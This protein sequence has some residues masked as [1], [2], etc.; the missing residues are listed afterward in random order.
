MEW[1]I[2]IFMRKHK[3]LIILLL[4]AFTFFI[5][6]L[7]SL[8]C[9][10]M[11]VCV[12]VCCYSS[13]SMCLLSLSLFSPWH[14]YNIEYVVW[15]VVVLCSSYVYLPLWQRP[16]NTAQCASNTLGTHVLSIIPHH[17]ISLFDLLRVRISHS[18]VSIHTTLQGVRRNSQ[19]SSKLNEN[20]K[21]IIYKKWRR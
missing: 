8:R 1:R 3:F 12:C 2:E 14:P 7:L 17:R 4:S 11:R 6:T 20:K 18:F 9:M 13:G 19:R 16:T 15:C 21:K 10:V 5:H